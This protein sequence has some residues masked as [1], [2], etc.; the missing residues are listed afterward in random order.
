MLTTHARACQPA[1]D[2]HRQPIIAQ[3]CCNHSLQMVDSEKQRWQAARA[4]Y[5]GT[6][7]HTVNTVAQPQQLT[8]FFPSAV[9]WQAKRKQLQESLVFNFDGFE[10]LNKRFSKSQLICVSVSPL[11]DAFT[12]SLSNQ[13]V[14]F[15]P[16][17]ILRV[18][19]SPLLHCLIFILFQFRNSIFK[20]TGLNRLSATLLLWWAVAVHVLRVLVENAAFKLI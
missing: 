6:S 20:S 2:A 3:R 5:R 12:V 17:I 19:P 8:G 14:K 1:T 13:T 11:S 10:G 4:A 18:C 15:L 16:Y 7:G 9:V